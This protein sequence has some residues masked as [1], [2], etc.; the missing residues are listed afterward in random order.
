MVVSVLNKELEYK[1][2]ELRYKKLEVE[3]TCFDSKLQEARNTCERKLAKGRHS[4]YP[5]Y[6]PAKDNARQ[7]NWQ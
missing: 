3:I 2:E 5:R 4:I 7:T 6:I 1:V